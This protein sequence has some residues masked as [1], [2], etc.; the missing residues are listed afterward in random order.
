MFDAHLC[1]PLEGEGDGTS[2]L[3][4]ARRA[5]DHLPEGL[6]VLVL[7]PAVDTPELRAV[8]PDWRARA[9]DYALLAS[10]AWPRALEAS[11]V[12]LMRMREVRAA[13]R[14]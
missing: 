11:G 4:A 2:R 10:D 5:L 7:H 6:S 12:R 13:V 14:S 9:A 8:A 3:E 1:L